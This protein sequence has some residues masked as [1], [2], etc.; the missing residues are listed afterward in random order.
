MSENG[1]S[2]GSG[3]V[4]AKLKYGFNE[5]KSSLYVENTA[6]A[7]LRF[8]ALSLAL[9]HRERGLG[10]RLSLSFRRFLTLVEA[11]ISEAPF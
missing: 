5:L 7:N 6:Q 10:C 9:S 4:S 1:A 8:A 3:G 11:A 2:E